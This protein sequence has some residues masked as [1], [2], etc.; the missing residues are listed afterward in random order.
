MERNVFLIIH[1]Y[2]EVGV[3]SE[4]ILL[5]YYVHVIYYNSL[6]LYQNYLACRS[7]NI[8]VIRCKIYGNR[9]AMKP[10]NGE[11]NTNL[12]EI[13]MRDFGSV[14]TYLHT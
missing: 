8:I 2:I 10:P 13:S 12:I 3:L 11:R 1:E 9:R 14:F 6:G 7:H 5:L 4:V